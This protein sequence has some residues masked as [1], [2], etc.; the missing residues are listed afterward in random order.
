LHELD[1]SVNFMKSK[2]KILRENIVEKHKEKKL[3]KKTIDDNLKTLD[4]T[5]KKYDPDRIMLDNYKNEVKQ[6]G[7]KI[8]SMI[9]KENNIFNKDKIKI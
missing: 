1:E 5:L 8:K 3:F 7:N 9:V 4:N 2:K 6:I